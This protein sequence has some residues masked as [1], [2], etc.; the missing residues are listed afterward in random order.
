MLIFPSLSVTRSILSVSCETC[1]END[2]GGVGGCCGP[3]LGLLWKIEL[4]R[5][6][7]QLRLC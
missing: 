2:L 5:S 4:R 6:V 1:P 7:D 3:M